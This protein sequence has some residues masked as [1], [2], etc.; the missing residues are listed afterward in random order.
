MAVTAVQ[1]AHFEDH[2]S[3]ESRRGEGLSSLYS[4]AVLIILALQSGPFVERA[5]ST[6]GGLC[7]S[8]SLGCRGAF[9]CR[10][11]LL[12]MMQLPGC[13]SEAVHSW[14][15]LRVDLNPST[16]RQNCGKKPSD[17][18]RVYLHLSRLLVQESRS[19]GGSDLGHQKH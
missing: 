15:V 14:D 9:I 19:Y 3:R 5:L 17:A 11:S 2:W 4:W 6:F 12:A 18:L 10:V 8:S 1:E 7:C 13:R 16:W